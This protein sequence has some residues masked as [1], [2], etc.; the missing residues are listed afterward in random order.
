MEAGC[1]VVQV[2]AWQQL[3]RLG[4]PLVRKGHA[5]FQH[6]KN[7]CAYTVHSLDIDRRGLRERLLQSLQSSI[8]TTIGHYHYT[9]TPAPQRP[10]LESKPYIQ[11]EK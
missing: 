4:T 1:R 9:Q 5:T 10:R 3:W 7:K 6:K 11:E 8:L 2:G